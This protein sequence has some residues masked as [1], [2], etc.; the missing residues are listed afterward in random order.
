MKP[1]DR[2]EEG[3]TGSLERQG[4]TEGRGRR[5]RSLGPKPIREQ[6]APT[7]GPRGQR[8]EEW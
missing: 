4:M 5:N 7:V 8:E 2:E 3:E 1:D 6:L